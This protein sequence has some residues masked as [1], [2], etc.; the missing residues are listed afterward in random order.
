[1]NLS[2]RKGKEYERHIARTLQDALDEPVLRTPAQEKWKSRYG[3]VN[4]RNPR[5]IL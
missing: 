4:N 2:Q 1:M 3:D 5:S